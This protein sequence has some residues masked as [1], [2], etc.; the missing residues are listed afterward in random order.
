MTTQK[1]TIE[2]KR[3]MDSFDLKFLLSKQTLNELIEVMFSN[4]ANSM[5]N[6]WSVT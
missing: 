1:K 6:N 4:K 3:T 2:L 5:I